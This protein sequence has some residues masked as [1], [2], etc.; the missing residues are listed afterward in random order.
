M[1]IILATRN[2]SKAEQIQAIFAGAPLK[3]LTLTQAGIEGE[4]IEDGETLEHNCLKKAQ[5]AWEQSHRW[6]MADDTGVFIDALGGVPGV[7]AANW[8]GDVSTEEAMQ[9]ILVRMKDVPVGKRTATFRTLATVIAPDG[10][11]TT[12]IGEA[13]G[14]ILEAP[15]GTVQRNMPYSP[16]FV[17]DG[18]AKTWSEM[19][20]EEENAVSHRGKSFRQVREFLE[21][22]IA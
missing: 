18:Q 1:D 3:I 16:I 9:F 12:F 19:T 20:L 4:G 14:I 10:T 22:Q 2:P 21:K 11:V 15:R 5:Y 8:A 13:P 7:H 6:T 17:P